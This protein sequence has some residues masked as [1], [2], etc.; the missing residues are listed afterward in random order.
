MDIF[1]LLDEEDSV[2]SCGINLEETDRMDLDEF[3]MSAV[4]VGKPH[5]LDD[6]WC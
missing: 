4:Q 3:F 2:V 1:L 6:T 5:G